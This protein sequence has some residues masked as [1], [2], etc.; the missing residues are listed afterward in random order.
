MFSGIVEEVGIVESATDVRG[1]R[2][3]IIAAEKVLE[4]LRVSDSI[5]VDGVCQTVVQV[6]REVF[7]VQA[8]AT[9]LSRTTLAELRRGRKAHRRGRSLRRP[10]RPGSRG[11]RWG[12]DLGEAAGRD[13]AGSLQPA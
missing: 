3:I 11:R 12:C 9:T 4:D 7:K 13:V 2:D 8:I 1:R 10:L 6:G 5:N